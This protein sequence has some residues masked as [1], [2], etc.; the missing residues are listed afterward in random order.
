MAWD[1]L[2]KEIDA[3][4]A[5]EHIELPGTWNIEDYNEFTLL[6]TDLIE[7]DSESINLYHPLPMAIQFH[8][9]MA[10]EV[11]LS[12]SNRAGKTAATSAEIAMAALGCHYLPYKYPREGCQIACVGND[13]RHLALMYEYLFEKAAFQVF[14]HPITGEWRVVSEDDEI[15]LKYAYLWKPSKPMIPERMVAEVAWDDK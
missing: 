8:H 15:C 4:K 12:G 7:R 3:I 13:G 1:D 9:C 10:H 11:G 2:D 5:R 6:V 14:Q